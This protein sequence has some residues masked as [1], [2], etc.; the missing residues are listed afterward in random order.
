MVLYFRETMIGVAVGLMLLG[1]FDDPEAFLASICLFLL[2]IVIQLEKVL[3]K[4]QV[5]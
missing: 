3:L 4:G 2:V 1:I 5:E